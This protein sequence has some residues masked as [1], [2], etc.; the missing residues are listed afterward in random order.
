MNNRILSLTAILASFILYACKDEIMI[1]QMLK[2]SIGK[3]INF[4]NIEPVYAFKTDSVDI[5]HNQR[6]YKILNYIDSVGCTKCKLRMDTWKDYIEELGSDVDFLFYFHPKNEKELLSS[7]RREYF[8]NYPVY[9]D[10][11]D[12][13]NRLNRFPDNPM[14]QCFLLNKDNKVLAVGN[15]AA[16]IRIWELYKR[17]ITG[18]ISDK[19]SATIVEAEQTEIELKDLHIGKTSEAVFTLKNTGTQPLII[20]TVNASCGCSV[21]EW[22]KQPVAAG[23]STEIKVKITLEKGEYFNKTVT[24]HCNTEEGQILLK[25]KGMVKE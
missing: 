5:V 15:P 13:L 14:F 17:I 24:V 11:N 21:P 12:E 19:F 3:V 16:N 2:N 22:E 4:P 18:E 1:E 9:I 10:K 8:I 20:Q 25:V 23:K 7:L 6:N